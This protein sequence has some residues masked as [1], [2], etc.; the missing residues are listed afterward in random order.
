MIS[1]IIFSW[2]DAWMDHKVWPSDSESVTIYAKEIIIFENGWSLSQWSIWVV[3]QIPWSIQVCFL[4]FKTKFYLSI[5]LQSI[6]TSH[7][8]SRFIS[9]Y[10]FFGLFFKR[11][12]KFKNGEPTEGQQPPRSTNGTTSKTPR[13]GA[14]DHKDKL[15][16]NSHHEPNNLTQDQSIPT[17]F[18]AFQPILGQK[19]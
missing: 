8:N 18:P 10:T 19:V 6:K 2:I 12:N 13:G 7:P 16:P 5:E 9:T 4:G 3:C 17:G 11:E 15:V 1:W 14:P